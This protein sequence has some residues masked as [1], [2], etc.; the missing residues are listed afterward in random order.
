MKFIYKFYAK[1][2]CC[3]LKK[4]LIF[5]LIF[6]QIFIDVLLLYKISER[7]VFGVLILVFM[8]VF[9][10]GYFLMMLT[11]CILLILVLVPK[12][13]KKLGE[14]FAKMENLKRNDF[15]SNYATCKLRS[16]NGKEN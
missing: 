6:L 1:I 14:E 13:N 5:C 7:P 10:L 9:V 3:D 15:L 2:S 8:F 4:A 11:V 12:T 16:N